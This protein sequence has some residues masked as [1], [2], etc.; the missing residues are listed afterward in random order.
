VFYFPQLSTGAVSQYPL[1]RRSSIRTI[2]NVLD[3]GRIVPMTDAG[4]RQTSWDV[5]YKDIADSDFQAI[6][7]LFASV[8]GRLQQFTLLDPAGNLLAWSE[9]LTRSVWH[10]DPLVQI[11]G[12]ADDPYGGQAAQTITNTAQVSQGVTQLIP[13][14]SWYEYCFSLYLRSDQDVDVQLVQTSASGRASK[15]YSTA[16]L[17]SRVISGCRLT[18]QDEG[19]SFGLEVPAGASVQAFG[20]QVEVQPSPGGYKKTTD[21]SGVFPQSRFDDDTLTAVRSAPGLNSCQMKIVSLLS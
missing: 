10:V 9:D 4:T 19:V 2:V 15:T 12:G 21:L 20:F 6:Q 5:I 13:A 14:P 16:A 1:T 7:Q 11:S 17:W 3:D 18:A 8:Q